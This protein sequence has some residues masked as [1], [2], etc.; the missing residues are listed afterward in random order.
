MSKKVNFVVNELVIALQEAERNG[1]RVTIS[2]T[3]FDMLRP[4]VNVNNDNAVVAPKHYT[5]GGVEPLDYIESRG[6][7]FCVGNAVKYISRASHKDNIVQDLKKA[8]FYLIRQMNRDIPPAVSSSDFIMAKGLT[9]NLANALLSIEGYQYEMA[10][11]YLTR[12][13]KDLMHDRK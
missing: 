5:H 2:D 6:Y 1:Q 11:D 10:V 9:P 7:G 13:I 4:Y 8:R 12:E 3:L